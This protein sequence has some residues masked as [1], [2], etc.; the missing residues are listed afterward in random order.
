MKLATSIKEIKKNFSHNEKSLPAEDE[1][2]Y[3]DSLFGEQMR[4]LSQNIEDSDI[5]Y[6]TFYI[7]GQSGNGKSTA[8]NHLKNT[9][10]YI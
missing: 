9:D 10:K 8:L 7:T 3:E 1:N 6:D 5:N 2:V 4:K